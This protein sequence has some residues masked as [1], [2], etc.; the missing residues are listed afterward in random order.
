MYIS[1]NNYTPKTYPMK[2]LL[3]SSFITVL[4]LSSCGL[5]Y[6]NYNIIEYDKMP[7]TRNHNTCKM[8]TDSVAI[9]AVFVDV[10]IYHPWTEFD[11]ASTMDSINKACQWLEQEASNR[12]IHLNIKPYFHEQGSKKTIYEKSAKASL[13]LNGIRSANNKSHKKL[14]PWADAISKY[15]GKGLKYKPSTKIHQRFKIENTQTLNLALRDE[16]KTENVAIMYFVNG[17]Y[18]NHPS[19]SFY[20]GTES[21]KVEYSIVTTKN[22]SVIAHEFLHLFGAVDLYP[23]YAFPNF[24]FEEL[25]SAF[26]NEIMLVQHKQLS[27]LMIS[28]ISAYFIGWQDTLDRPNT[29]LLFHKLNVTE[30]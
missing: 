29:R 19:Y 30:Y 20:T 18:E 24:N 4:I 28:P 21:Q 17:Y 12:S 15:A 14:L 23:H 25:Q 27:K 7:N 11:I 16:F 1:F 3:T 26:P 5:F 8:L 2:Q 9:Y 22:P 10:D 6:H 13:S